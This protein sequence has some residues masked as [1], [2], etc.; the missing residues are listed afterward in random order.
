MV[1]VSIIQ[2]IAGEYD[3][4]KKSA[5]KHKKTWWSLCACTECNVLLTNLKWEACLF[6]CFVCEQ[7]RVSVTISFSQF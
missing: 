2:P 1:T 5:S 7:K 3:G 4:L 6:L